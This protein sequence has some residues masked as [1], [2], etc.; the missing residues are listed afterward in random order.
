[1]K[2]I[3]EI[4]LAGFMIF[5]L[6]FAP[7]NAENYRGMKM[8]TIETGARAAGMGGAFTAVSGDPLAA[9]YNPAATWGI[10]KVTGTIGYNT[11][12]ENSS[13][14][15]GYISFKKKGVV[16]TSGIQYASITNLEGRDNT[17]SEDYVEFAYHD[18]ALKIGA[19]FE[20]D[21]NY[22]LGFSVGFLNEKID[23]HSGSAFNFDLGLLIEATPNL[24]VG[25]S[26]INFGSTIKVYEEAYDIPTTYRAG[27]SYKYNNLLGA[28]GVSYLES[29]MHFNL[30]AEYNFY[31]DFYARAGYRGG[32]D[33][34]DFSAGV[35]FVKR[36]L[37]I[38][39]AFLPYGGGLDDSH[40]INLT[41]EI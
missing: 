5:L 15:A 40:L 11:H 4:T 28:V 34:I 1:M 21:S 19:A 17:P 16:V 26:V 23:I 39:Y 41:F 7:A 6:G 10:E 32:Y 3:I 8:L 22:Y 9:A 38:D 2:K 29:E 12:W 30:G 31:N 20:L 36:N 24:N 14:Q 25:L 13:L 27:L 37:R 33:T 18:V 35:G